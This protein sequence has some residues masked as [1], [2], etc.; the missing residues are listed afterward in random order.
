MSG[1]DT[2]A[3]LVIGS[4]GR[5]RCW[6]A[7]SGNDELRRYHDEEWGVPVHDDRLLFEHICLEGFQAGLSWSTVLNKRPAF[8]R[9]FHDFEIARVARID[10]RKIE[11][12][13]SDPAIIR[14]RAKIEAAISNARITRDLVSA[15]LG[16][17]NNLIWSFAP[18]PRRRRLRS[19]AEVPAV[20]PEAEALSTELRT[21]GFRFVGPTTMYALMQ[22]AGLVDD[23]IAGCHRAQ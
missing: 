2:P 20:T 17:L 15:Q 10:S 9:H 19:R 8:R 16:A 4:D 3:A 21:R 13:M 7:E 1:R 23:H 14:N 11:R 22:S 12:M 6:W 5:G 18:S